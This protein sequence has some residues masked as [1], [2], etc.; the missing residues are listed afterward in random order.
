MFHALNPIFTI[1]YP[2][3]PSLLTK[4]FNLKSLLIAVKVI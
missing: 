3:H 1:F 4:K 2:I